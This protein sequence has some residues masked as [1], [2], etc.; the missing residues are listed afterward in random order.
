MDKMTKSLNRV[1][2]EIEQEWGKDKVEIWMRAHHK[3]GVIFAWRVL[4]KDAPV[5]C[6]AVMDTG[7]VHRGRHDALIGLFSGPGDVAIG[8]KKKYHDKY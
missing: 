7:E 3:T 1:I 6:F 5:N 4:I 2:G 8:A